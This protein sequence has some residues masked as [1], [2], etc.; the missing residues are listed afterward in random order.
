L[1]Y[2]HFISAA[3]TFKHIGNY[4]P[5]ANSK[6]YDLGWLNIARDQMN[7]Q[8]PGFEPTPADGE[9]VRVRTK[10]NYIDG[11]GATNAEG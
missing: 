4:V 7:P 11:I 3:C 9:K 10:F 2:P 8:L 6:H 1:Q 5:A